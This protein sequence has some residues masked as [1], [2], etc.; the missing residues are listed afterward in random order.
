MFAYNASLILLGAKVLLSN[1]KVAELL[2]PAIHP[3][4]AAVER[5]H[6][7]PKG[8]LST[9]KIEATRETNQIANYAYVEWGDNSKISN[10]SPEKYLPKLKARFSNAELAWMYHC[11]ALP[12]KWVQMDYH[13][14]LENRREMMAQ[15]IREGYQTLTEGPASQ[16][17][18]EEFD[19]MTVISTGENDAV[20]FKSTLRINLHTGASDKRMELAV[21]KRP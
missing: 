12:E 1:A 7:F 6:L 5:H 15:I 3:N 2:D 21:L 4:R 14:F 11:H 8:Y 10:D 17:V 13:A 16:V 9:L 18:Q 20:E 19:L